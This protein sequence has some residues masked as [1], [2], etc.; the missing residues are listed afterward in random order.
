MEKDVSEE[1][2]AVLCMIPYHVVDVSVFLTTV[3]TVNSAEKAFVTT[4]LLRIFMNLKIYKILT[5]K[6]LPTV[7]ISMVMLRRQKTLKV[8]KSNLSQLGGF[9]CDLC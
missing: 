1:L 4:A 2:L 7:P 3:T 5:S 8:S 9:R 6:N